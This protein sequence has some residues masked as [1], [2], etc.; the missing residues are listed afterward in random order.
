MYSCR[1]VHTTVVRVRVCPMES[2]LSHRPRD[3]LPPAPT[4]PCATFPDPRGSC[5]ASGQGL[6]SLL[7]TLGWTSSAPSPLAGF[8]VSSSSFSLCLSSGLGTETHG[9][10]PS[11]TGLTSTWPAGLLPRAGAEGPS[12]ASLLPQAGPNLPSLG[13]A[14][15]LLRAGPHLASLGGADLLPR[16]G[17]GDV[18]VLHG[19]VCAAVHSFAIAKQY[20]A[21]LPLPPRGHPVPWPGRGTRRHDV[22]P[23]C[24]SSLPGGPS[25]PRPGRSARHSTLT[26]ISE[27]MAASLPIFRLAA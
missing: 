6:I 9:P 24:T 13:R 20:W 23:S 14:S 22:L 2:R 16:L 19:C 5:C 10:R 27:S 11:G 3:S 25:G 18:L 26:D 15:L 21:A 4:H 12:G 17:D 7:P 1:A 8:T